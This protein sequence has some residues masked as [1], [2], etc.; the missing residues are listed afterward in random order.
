MVE[1]IRVSPPLSHEGMWCLVTVDTG[2]S[3][4]HTKVLSSALA[5]AKFH[6]HSCSEAQNTC[7]GS[8]INRVV[9]LGRTEEQVFHCNNDININNNNNNI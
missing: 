5:Q 9:H 8:E 4:N 6:T 7:S 3:K 2:E 1:A